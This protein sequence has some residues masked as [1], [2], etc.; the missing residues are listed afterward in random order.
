[1]L[2][3][4]AMTPST[5]NNRDR[6]QTARGDGMRLRLGTPKIL[7]VAAVAASISAASVASA[8]TVD[9]LGW[10]PTDDPFQTGASSTSISGRALLDFLD[11]AHANVRADCDDGRIKFFVGMSN[12]SVEPSGPHTAKIDLKL[13]GYVGYATVELTGNDNRFSFVA[14][15]SRDFVGGTQFLIGI[16]INGTTAILRVSLKEPTVANFVSKCA[17]V[18]AA[19]ERMAAREQAA[20]KAEAKAQEGRR[21]AEEAARQARIRAENEQLQKRAADAKAACVP[22]RIMRLTA[23]PS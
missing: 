21:Q 9:V 3:L 16:P 23:N 18:Q 20:A 7:P 19:S 11:R 13:D 12:A 22:G 10:A 5:A 4:L 1:M 14:A 6:S 2:A 17:V 15:K 8:G